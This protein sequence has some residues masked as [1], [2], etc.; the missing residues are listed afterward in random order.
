MPGL[1][2]ESPFMMTSTSKSTRRQSV[3]LERTGQHTSSTGRPN[4][5]VSASVIKCFVVE[6]HLMPS[7][8]PGCACNC[9]TCCSASKSFHAVST[10]LM[11][12]SELPH[13][14]TCLSVRLHCF[15]DGHAAV[16]VGYGE[17]MSCGCMACLLCM[18]LVSVHL[19]ACNACHTPACAIQSISDMSHRQQKSSDRRSS[20]PAT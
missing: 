4:Q 5:F 20:P 14:V 18:C 19:Q 17:C 16:I 11:P 2:T 13:G 1:C 7:Q 10:S 6:L 8:P 9:L 3:C 12:T 15:A